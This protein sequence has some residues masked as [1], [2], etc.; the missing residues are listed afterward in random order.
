MTQALSKILGIP[1]KN[2]NKSEKEILSGLKKKLTTNEAQKIV[3][4][5]VYTKWGKLPQ[6]EHKLVLMGYTRSGKSSFVEKYVHNKFQEMIEPT[7]GAAF[8]AKTE[9]MFG[10][11]LKHQMWDTAGDDRYKALLPMYYRGAKIV[12]LFFSLTEKKT[13]DKIPTYN[14]DIT[15]NSKPAL[16]ILVGTKSDLKEKR[17]V[18][19]DTIEEYCIKNKIKY[20]ECSSKTGENIQ[21]LMDYISRYLCEEVR[22]ATYP[23]FTWMDTS[24]S[25][26]SEV[27]PF[28]KELDFYDL[29][30]SEILCDEKIQKIPVHKLFLEKRL[31]ME[32]NKIA[33]LLK[34]ISKETV[35]LF[36]DWA[37]GKTEYPNKEVTNL[38]SQ[39]FNITDLENFNLS[40]TLND[41]YRDDESK[42]FKLLVQTNIDEENEE[43]KE[44]E[45]IPIHKFVL[46]A[47]SGLFREMFQN[48]DKKQKQINQIKDYTGKSIESLEILIKFF[49]TNLIEFTAD[50]DQE[51]VLEELADA[52]EYY[53][54]NEKSTLKK[55]LD[56]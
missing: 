33:E 35:N 39:H 30:K 14:Q 27:C 56:K 46:L 16:K 2:L 26:Y 45:D 15:K 6:P 24:E 11:T 18:A 55:L 38:L 32:F 51:L 48:L 21:V 23:N 54:L 5:R 20:F 3:S 31:S 40:R 4:Q 34:N 19:M 8:L 42:D 43:D 29:F 25:Y 49:Y 9:K 17:V 10:L 44:F 47:R 7:I 37:Y 41:L 12:L 36:L 22:K 1:N 53:Q 50:D 52:H 28:T 13:W